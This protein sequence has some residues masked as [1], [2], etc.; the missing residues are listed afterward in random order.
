MPLATTL[1]YR[2]G[3][4]LTVLPTRPISPHPHYENRTIKGT[5]AKA[6]Q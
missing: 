2:Y 4:F 1:W 6:D 3:K 5:Q